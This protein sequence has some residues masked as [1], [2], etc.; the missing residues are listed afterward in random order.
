V[1]GPSQLTLGVAISVPSP[2]GEVLTDWRKRVGDPAAGR[3]FPHV[4]LLPPTE[5]P[6]ARMPA[7]EDHLAAVAATYPPFELHLAGTGT[8]R[9]VSDVVFVVVAAGIAQCEQLEERVRSGPL[10]RETRFPYHPHVTVAHDIPDEGLD[11][12]YEGLADFDAR[13]PVPAFTVFEQETGG[14]WAQRKEFVLRG[15]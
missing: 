11:R 9:P 2:W 10:A 15:D 7:I 3:V 1:S 5:V 13:F 12:A 6:A 8:F 14:V 4:T